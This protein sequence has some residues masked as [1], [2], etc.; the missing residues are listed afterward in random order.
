MTSGS[1]VDQLPEH[2]FPEFAIIGR[3]NVGKSSLLNSVLKHD[4][5]RTSRTPGRTQL[6]NMFLFDGSIA[7]VDLP[8]YGYAQMSK[9]QRAQMETMI[10]DYLAKRVGLYGVLQL[11]DARRETPSEADH[12]VSNWI[13]EHNRQLL[14]VLTKIDLVPKNTLRNRANAIQKAIGIPPDA[15]V[16]FSSKTGAGR[17]ELVGRLRELK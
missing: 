7:V 6:L 4:L 12:Q 17:D 13:L 3:S 16:L 5:V 15:A 8:G 14:V 11:F 10:A 9:T 2:D 1:K